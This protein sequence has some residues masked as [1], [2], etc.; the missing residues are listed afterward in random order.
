M[1]NIPVLAALLLVA[2]TIYVVVIEILAI[3]A[4]GEETEAVKVWRPGSVN[5]PSADR[6]YRGIR[7]LVER[8]QAIDPAGLADIASEEAIPVRM[9]S[10]VFFLKPPFTSD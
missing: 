9:G 3:R 7:A 10:P 6:V 5:S 4:L 8:R 1:E 2:V